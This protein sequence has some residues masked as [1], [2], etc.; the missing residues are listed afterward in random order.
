MGRFRINRKFGHEDRG[1]TEMTLL[2]QDIVDC[3]KYIMDLR[4]SRGL[5]DDIDHLGNRRVRTIAELAGDEFRKGLLK[6]RRTAAERMNNQETIQT[7]TPRQLINSKTISSAIEY[8]FGRGELSQVVDQSNPLSQLTHERR[9]SAL[10]GRPEPQARALTCATAHR[11]TAASARSDAGRQQ[12]RPDRPLAL[13]ARLDDGLLVTP[14]RKVTRQGGR[15]RVNLRADEEYD[16]ARAGGH[17]W[18]RRQDHRR[19]GARASGRVQHGAGE[20]G[21]VHRHRPCSWACRPR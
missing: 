11:T 17:W 10:G 2:A 14:Y 6:L 5:V 16:G 1:D 18:T 12:H 7:A 9:L 20:R 4:A 3:I 15:R 21:A 8:F 13:Y 19:H